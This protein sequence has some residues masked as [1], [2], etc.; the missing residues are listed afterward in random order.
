[1]MEWRGDQIAKGEENWIFDGGGRGGPGN[2]PENYNTQL[3]N[4]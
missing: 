1:M 2:A 3:A 4:H